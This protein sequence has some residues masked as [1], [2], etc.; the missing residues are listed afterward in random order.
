MGLPF[1]YN[2]LSE[3]IKMCSKSNYIKIVL[4]NILGGIL[5][6]NCNEIKCKRRA[7]F[8]Y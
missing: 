7:N 8:G 6:G 3:F 1:F 4:N 2:H 5:Y